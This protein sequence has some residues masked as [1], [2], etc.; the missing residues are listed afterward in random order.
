MPIEEPRRSDRI[1]V[2]LPIA[3]SGV[4]ASGEA[5][6]EHSV[7]VVL[8]RHGAKI[9]LSRMLAPDQEVNIRCLGSAKESEARVVGQIGNGPE[10]YY[11]GLELL[12][13]GADF[14]DIEFPPVA[15]TDAAVGRVLLGCRRCG[16]R[17]LA[18]LNEF[19]T[20]VL[21]A[22]QELWR[23]CKKCSDTT[24]WRKT[25]LPPTEDSSVQLPLVPPATAQSRRTQNDRKHVR[26]DLKVPVCIRH[27]QYTGDDLVMTENVSRG[28]FRFKSRR[29][30][31]Q[32]WVLEVALPYSRGSAN[33]FTSAQVVYVGELPVEGLAVYGSAYVPGSRVRPP[34]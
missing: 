26:L 2:E 19:Q 31:G 27:P 7:T 23:R 24:L 9:A 20:E 17:E 15:K 3:I 13:N 8:G 25:N 22:N 1:A 32:D 28:G 6:L 10:G 21:E 16:T 29:H 4:D 11:Y 12:D 33:I 14:W 18:Y 30:Y 34:H 5:F